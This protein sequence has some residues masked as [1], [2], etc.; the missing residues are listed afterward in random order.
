[1][2]GFGL[3]PDAALVRTV[4]IWTREMVGAP[5]QDY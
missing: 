1:M 2:T 3:T 5:D 4:P